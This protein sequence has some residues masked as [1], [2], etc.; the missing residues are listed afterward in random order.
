MPKRKTIRDRVKKLRRVKA[1]ELVPHPGN[2]RTH[3]KEQRDALRGLLAEIG[4]C[5]TLLV[6]ELAD[7]RFGII[8]GHLRAEILPEMEVPV[9]VLDLSEK[10]AKKLLLSLD[11]LVG[12]A[13]PNSEAL[14]TLLSKI[15]FATEDVGRMVEGLVAERDKDSTPLKPLELKPP[16][17]MTWALIGI[18]TV[19]FGEIAETIEQLALVDEI[20]LET[21]SNDG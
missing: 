10:E 2:W 20:I 4:F 9:L 1:S 11:P 6:R 19:R 14:E 15:S 8:D 12:L 16:P 18:P 5:D 13:E 3:P 21:T 7:G 17:E